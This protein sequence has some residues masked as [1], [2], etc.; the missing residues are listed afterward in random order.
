VLGIDHINGGGGKHRKELTIQG[1]TIYIFLKRNNYP[2][3]YQVLC[4]NCNLAKGFYGECP[5]TIK[6]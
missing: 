4:H 3:E 6:T 2:K 5:H 1:I